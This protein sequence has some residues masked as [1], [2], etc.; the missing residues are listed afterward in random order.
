MDT[1]V[2]L[3]TPTG[4]GGI[5]VVR[6]SGPRVPAV[7]ERLLGQI[8]TPRFATYVRIRD[9]QGKTLDRGIALYFPEPHSFT[10]EHVLE[11][12]GHGAPVVP[13][14]DHQGN[15]EGR[16]TTRWPRGSSAKGHSSTT[17]LTLP[18]QKR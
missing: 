2:A 5:G 4:R 12:H 16:R 1:I 10:G 17:R 15:I 14:Y 8:P 13:R 7:S 6:V 18:R 3:A 11:L 9:F